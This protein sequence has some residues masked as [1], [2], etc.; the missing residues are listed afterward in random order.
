MAWARIS[1]I[2]LAANLAAGCSAQK[3]VEL[4]DVAPEY[5]TFVR[6]MSFHR[7]CDYQHVV[8]Q[9]DYDDFA[10]MAAEHGADTI[11][12]CAISDEEVVL[13]ATSRSGKSCVGAVERTALAYR[14]DGLPPGR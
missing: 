13:L 2:L 9:E 4:V 8:Y 12:C 5:C 3:T 7:L 1:C 14:C 11:E 10:D 6:E